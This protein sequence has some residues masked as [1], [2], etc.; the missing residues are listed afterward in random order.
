[1]QNGRK[2]GE[3]SR[4]YLL[5]FEPS[6][7]SPRRDTWLSYTPWI[8]LIGP[9]CT[10][11]LRSLHFSV[12]KRRNQAAQWLTTICHQHLLQE[13]L[14]SLWYQM[15]NEMKRSLVAIYKQRNRLRHFASLSTPWNSCI[16]NWEAKCGSR[17]MTPLGCYHVSLGNCAVNGIN[18]R[19]TQNMTIFAT[20]MPIGLTWLI[21]SSNSLHSNAFYNRRYKELPL[22]PS[23]N[24]SIHM[25][26]SNLKTNGIMIVQLL[27]EGIRWSKYSAQIHYLYCMII[28]H[29]VSPCLHDR[30]YINKKEIS[31]Q[32]IGF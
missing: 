26:Q 24:N 15:M 25:Q 11:K 20:G 28:N 12:D 4:S 13:I 30:H 27:K 18:Y 16:E 6:A 5:P 23:T 21:C 3:G 14:P 32:R 17:F 8:P 22:H 9:Q 1:M 7:I 29:G 10:C 31:A 2:D 19:I